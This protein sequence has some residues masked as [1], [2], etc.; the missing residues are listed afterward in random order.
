MPRQK[1]GK[2]RGTDPDEQRRRREDHTVQIR[3]NRQIEQIAK[4]RKVR[5]HWQR[6]RAFRPLRALPPALLFPALRLT[7]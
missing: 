7:G 6:A 4:H 5:G 3:K 1:E 2:A